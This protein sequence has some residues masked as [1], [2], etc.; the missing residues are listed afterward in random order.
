MA[1]LPRI[2]VCF[3]GNGSNFQALIDAIA[4]GTLRA[5]IVLGV[6]NRSK[7]YALERAKQANIPTKTLSLKPYKDQGKTREEYDVDLAQVILSAQPDL[8]VLAGFMHILSPAFLSHFPNTPLIN[9]HPAL[10]GQFDGAHAIERAFEAYKKGEIKHTGIMI[11]RVIAEVDGGE[12]L[13]VQEIEIKP[14]DDLDALETR[15]HAAEHVLIVKGSNLA[16]EQI[17]KSKATAA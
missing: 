7:A 15:I 5:N 4:Q 10:P 12:P 17:A 13:L 2:V 11:H 6:S 14:E 3:S 1:A 8:I 16:L 9:L